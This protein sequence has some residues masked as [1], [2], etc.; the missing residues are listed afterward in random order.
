MVEEFDE[1]L[2]AGLVECL[3]VVSLVEVVFVLKT[4]N[5]KSC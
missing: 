4:K 5:P 2:F 1:K 3:R